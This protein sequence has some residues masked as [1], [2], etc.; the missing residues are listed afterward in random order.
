MQLTYGCEP[1]PENA[2][3]TRSLIMKIEKLL[4]ILGFFFICS[5][6]MP[7][8]AH[9]HDLHIG[10]TGG[11]LSALQQLGDAFANA[12]PG[13]SVEVLPSIGSNGGV[14]ALLDMAIDVAVIAR[15]LR[16]DE[17]LQGDL[18]QI[19]FVRTP[20]VLVTADLPEVNLTVDQMARMLTDPEATWP[21]G[22]PVRVIARPASESDY[23]AIASALPDLHAAFASA[24]SRPEVPVAANDQLNAGLAT[25]MRGS[26]TVATL[27]QV[28]SEELR[29]TLLPIDGV[30]PTILNMSSGRYPVSKD[31]FLVVHRNSDEK[32]YRFLNFLRLDPASTR[33]RRLG[34]L[35]LG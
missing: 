20:V 15:P 23:R 29:L 7:R 4:I 16:D 9:A 35:P 18:V 14:R 13:I 22:T 34:A 32:I 25:A 17:R 27:L 11:P 21:D 12:H 33:L 24:R 28:R 1:Y 10:G 2:R 30:A 8:E 26:L 19:P 3:G 31:F 5:F 6:A